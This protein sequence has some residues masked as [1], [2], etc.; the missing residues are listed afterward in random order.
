MTEQILPRAA[1]WLIH[2]RHF[3][4]GDLIGLELRPTVV[5]VRAGARGS[6]WC[7]PVSIALTTGRIAELYADV[8]PKNR[9]G[10]VLSRSAI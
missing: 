7:E 6:P 10:T 5:A 1:H 3:V 8:A 2:I 9:V 4:I